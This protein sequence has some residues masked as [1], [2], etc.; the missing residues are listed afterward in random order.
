[1]NPT[2]S[3]LFI[4]ILS[5][6]AYFFFLDKNSF[7]DFDGTFPRITHVKA[8]IS[9][10]NGNIVLSNKDRLILQQGSDRIVSFIRTDGRASFYEI[11]SKFHNK[12][13]QIYLESDGWEVTDISKKFT[14]NG[15][16]TTIIV[17]VKQKEFDIIKE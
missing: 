1:L 9:D 5:S 17:N 3:I 6:L 16:D 7:L 8:L 15:G 11:P 10:E 2:Q 14:Y 4:L 13:I 12:E